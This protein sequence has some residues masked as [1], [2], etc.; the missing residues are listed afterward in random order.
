VEVLR[1]RKEHEAR[2]KG[3]RLSEEARFL[4]GFH[5]LVSTLP[6]PQWPVGLVLELY[7]ARWQIEILFKR[8]KQVLNVHRL[9]CQCAQ[10]AQA[11][12]A[13]LLVGWLLVEEQT[14]Q[15][16]QQITDA[17]PLAEPISL[18][19]LDRLTFS[20]LQKVIEGWWSPGH[21]IALASEL[22][23]LFRERRRRPRREHHWRS[24]FLALLAPH[25]DLVSFFDCS[26]A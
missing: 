24:R 15:M 19:Q 7:R 14:T 3:R 18:W 20:G 4:A 17:E 10:T 25:L 16:R 8:I 11:M 9:A 21:L 5:L 6:E 1:R 23:R 22:R 12:I 26:S 2:D 13:V